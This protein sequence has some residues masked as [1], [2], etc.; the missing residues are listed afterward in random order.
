M[1]PRQAHKALCLHKDS[2][3]DRTRRISGDGLSANT[4]RA[5]LT[6][7]LACFISRIFR[8]YPPDVQHVQKETPAP[9]T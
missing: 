1:D 4:S 9:P 8:T 6:C 2:H 3:E 5:W 7:Q